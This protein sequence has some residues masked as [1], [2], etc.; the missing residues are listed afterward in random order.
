MSLR[1]TRFLRPAFGAV[2]LG[3]VVGALAAAERTVVP[4]GSADEG[5]P[6]PPL[7]V[8]QF[9]DDSG[10][11]WQ[12]TGRISGELTVAAGDF[13][14]C[15]SGQGW[16][17]H[18]DILMGDEPRRVLLTQWKKGSRK[19]IVMLWDRAAGQTGFAIGEEKSTEEEKKNH[20]EGRAL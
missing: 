13:E 16:Q 4:I 12:F 11:T 18:T 5:L 20:Q 6:L 2:L 9:K 14:M 7:A 3:A 15:L 8:V 19:L 1:E 10:K 17:W